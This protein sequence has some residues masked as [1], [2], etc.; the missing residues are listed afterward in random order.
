MPGAGA[1]NGT[2]LVLGDSLSAAYGMPRD[3]GWVALMQQ[4]LTDARPGT[5]VVNASISGATTGATL[6]RL[7]AL[8]ARHRPDLCIIELG[9]N[10]G[11]RG[12]SLDLI[13]DNLR[14]LVRGCRE[15]GARV[16]L[17]GMR[18]PPNYGRR[19]AD[20]FAAV[21][22]TLAQQQ[23]VILIEF[24]LDGVI[25]RREWM[26]DDGLHPTAAAQPS[27]LNAVWQALIG[28]LDIREQGGMQAPAAQAPMELSTQEPSTLEPL[29]S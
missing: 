13:T 1:G 25:Q 9:A 15:V 5:A 12:L 6:A 8:L 17:L 2:V 21:Y 22:R 3:S 18:V 19:Y 28:L 27:L 16:L 10:D 11:L 7:E 26:Q 24:F 20:G 23:Q 14:D 4:R 29:K